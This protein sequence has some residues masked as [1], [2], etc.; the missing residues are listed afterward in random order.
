MWNKANFLGTARRF[1]SCSTTTERVYGQFRP[2]FG[3]L[4]SVSPQCW[5][6]LSTCYAGALGG[7]VS[8]AYLEVLHYGLAVVW[9]DLPKLLMKDSNCILL[10]PTNSL[11]R[12]SLRSWPLSTLAFDSTDFKLL[13]VAHR[14]VQVAFAR[15]LLQP[16]HTVR[17]TVS[18]DT[19]QKLQNGRLAS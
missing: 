6:H 13:R 18:H 7:L 9:V 4:F 15:F 3:V 14:I 11:T 17:T 2:S 16:S 1:I 10:E 19:P 5:H 12:Y 8:T